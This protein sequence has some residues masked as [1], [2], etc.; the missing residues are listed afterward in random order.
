MVKKI[1]LG[2][3]G[4]LLSTILLGFG[5]NT[6]FQVLVPRMLGAYQGSL[7][8]YGLLF[9]LDT[10]L[11][12]AVCSILIVLLVV[13]FSRPSAKKAKKILKSKVENFESNLEN[14]RFMT[15]KERDLNFN[16]YQFTKLKESIGDE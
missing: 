10:Y 4:F 8:N 6:V 13:L 5:L 15:D 9:R 12:G 3:V 11:Y 1:L 7:I 2:V 14:S 16:P